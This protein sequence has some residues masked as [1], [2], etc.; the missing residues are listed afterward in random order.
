MGTHA[1]GSG[2][3]A[4]ARRADGRPRLPDGRFL[5]PAGSGV[6]GGFTGSAVRDLR[7][8]RACPG[9]FHRATGGP[10]AAPCPL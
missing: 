2:G 5:R 9:V 10:L 6:A 1:K 4:A 7:D 3:R 8:S